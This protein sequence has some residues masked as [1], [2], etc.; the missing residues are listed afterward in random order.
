MRIVYMCALYTHMPIDK[1]WI[2]IYIYR[3][4]FVCNFVCTITQNY[5]QTVEMRRSWNMARVGMCGCRSVA[6]DVFVYVPFSLFLLF[7]LIIK[8]LSPLSS[9]ERSRNFPT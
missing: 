7:L 2:Y 6:T 4:L 9:N 8:T 5:K 3:S 1:V